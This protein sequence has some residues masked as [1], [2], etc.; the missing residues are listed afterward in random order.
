MRL[1]LPLVSFDASYL[2]LTFSRSD[3]S[4]KKIYPNKALENINTEDLKGFDFIKLKG[5]LTRKE[6][7]EHFGFNKKKAERHFKVFVEQGFV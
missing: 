3:D 1:P 4:L 2:V 7:G 6:Y 5:V